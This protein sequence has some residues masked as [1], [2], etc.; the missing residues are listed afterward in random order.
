MLGADTPAHS[1]MM[2][3]VQ[4][5]HTKVLTTHRIRTRML[6]TRAAYANNSCKLMD[7]GQLLGADTHGVFDMAGL[8]RMT[9]CVCSVCGGM[10]VCCSSTHAVA[11]LCMIGRHGNT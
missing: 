10:R 9:P 5:A 4:Q 6:H 3:L 8:G 11:V 2:Q 7:I 1:K